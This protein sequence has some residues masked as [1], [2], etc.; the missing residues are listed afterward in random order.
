MP[1]LAYVN[2]QAG[3]ARVVIQPWAHA[4]RV[5]PGGRIDIVFDTKGVADPEI[6]VA[7]R[8]DGEVEIVLRVNLVSISGDG[9]EGFK[10]AS[11][12]RSTP[13]SLT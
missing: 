8:A 1:R 4:T 11:D 6:R 3:E 13:T 5:A 9:V 10:L 12:G 2:E 7:H